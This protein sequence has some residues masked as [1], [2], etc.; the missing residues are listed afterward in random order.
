MGTEAAK[1]DRRNT[2]NRRQLVEDVVLHAHHGVRIADQ[3]LRNR[4][5]HHLQRCG[6]GETGIDIAHR[7]EGADHQH[8]ADQQHQRHG[9]LGHHQQVAA[10]LPFAANARRARRLQATARRCRE[11]A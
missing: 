10:T 8:R 9:H 3:R 1:P 7:Q 5:A 4:D 6:I 2:R 11:G